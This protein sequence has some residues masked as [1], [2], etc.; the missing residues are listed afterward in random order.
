LTCFYL[1]YKIRL[2]FRHLF[3]LDRSFKGQ[4][5]KIGHV[6]ELLAYRGCR[7]ESDSEG[8]LVA[9]PVPE[10][11]D[12]LVWLRPLSS[13]W[14]VTDQIFGKREYQPVIELF[15]QFFAETP[16]RIIDCGAN[17]GLTSIWF[18]RHYPQVSITAVEPF[19]ANVRLAEK[20]LSANGVKNCTVMA[21]GIW[22]CETALSIDRTFRD[23]K[24]WSIALKETAAEGPSII[25]G[26]CLKSLI[27]ALDVPVDILKI[28]VEGA[29]RFIFRD[30]SYVRD[31]L[32]SVKCLVIEIHDEFDL[33]KQI[34]TKL[35]DCNFIYFNQGESTIAINRSFI[36][37]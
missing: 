12:C 14:K 22:D 32:R 20:N 10:Y 26:I 37:V 2:K 34:C 18:H 30:A 15:P 1:I 11:P 16:L 13:D 31:F 33:R 9:Y 6:Y 17:I 23:G 8:R 19:P 4:Q 35:T 7:Q 36:S 21:G 24:E 5:E 27:K 25:R 29:E 3:Q 28:D